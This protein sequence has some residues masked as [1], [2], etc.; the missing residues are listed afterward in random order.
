MCD[1]FVA[2]GL[3]QLLDVVPEPHGGRGAC[4]RAVVG[5]CWR[6]DPRAASRPS[7]TSGGTDR[8]SARATG[9]CCRL[10][11]DHYG[12]VLE[13]GG[14]A[15]GA[16]RD[17]I[18]VR[19]H[20]HEFPI[21]FEDPRRRAA[22]R[23]GAQRRGREA[24]ATD[25]R[26]GSLRLRAREPRRRGVRRRPAGLLCRGPRVRHYHADALRLDAV[27]A[28][29]N[30]WRRTSSTSA[31]VQGTRR[32]GAATGQARG[33]VIA[34]RSQRPAAAVRAREAGGYGLDGTRCGLPAEPR[35]GRQPRAR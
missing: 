10:L 4:E 7:S 8:K 31:R 12:R 28:I 18:V 19:Y 33:A 30:F 15:S 26:G 24:T 3:R 25:V 6:T 9:S 29:F 20:E 2:H 16:H 23:R 34:E 21:G 1:E 11:G 14:A 5:T 27:H 13:A 32:A 17:E 35:P 22:R